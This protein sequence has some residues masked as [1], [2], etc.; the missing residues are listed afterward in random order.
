MNNLKRYTLYILNAID[1]LSIILS[2]FA[3]YY[4]RIFFP[5]TESF[6]GN[7]AN[8]NYFLTVVLVA[9]F[10]VN[11]LL[12]YKDDK[13]L[14]RHPVKEFSA[15]VK[16]SSFVMILVLIYF[17]FAKLN[18]EFSRIFEI[19][20]FV[21]LVL[22]DTILRLMV[23]H[24]VL[25][26]RNGILNHQ[27]I[28]LIASSEDAEKYV[29]I[30]NRSKDW[31][32]RIT[33]VYSS[34]VSFKKKLKDVSVLTKEEEV[35]S[36]DNLD[37]ID[38]VIIFPEDGKEEVLKEW[39]NRFK[40]YGKT[41][42]VQIPQYSL[43][44]SF[45]SLDNIGD[46][47]VVTYRD[48]QPMSIRQQLFKRTID[49][50]I[51]VLFFPF[52]PL[53][54]LIVK[55]FT[56]IESP[57]PVLIRRV[58]VG[59]NNKRFYQYRFRVYRTDAAKRIK[60]KKSPY[61]LIGRFLEK[62]HLDG[63]PLLLNVLTGDM[64]FVGPKAPNLPRYLRMSATQRNL[65]SIR[66]GIVGYWTGEADDTKALQDETEYFE[67]WN[68]F[69][70]ISIVIFC[71]LRFFSFRSLRVHGETHVD[72]ELAFAAYIRERK[73]PIRY[74][75]ALYK[76]ESKPLYSFLKR[77]FDILFSIILIIVLSPLLLFVFIVIL[78]DDGGNPIYT[79]ERVGKDGVRFP[80]YKFRSMRMDAGNLKELL[81][82]EQYDQYL[83]EFK[84][85]NDP[86]ITPTG[87][88][89]RRSSLDELPQ[90]F[91]ILAGSMSFVGPRPILEE[92]VYQNYKK[93]EIAQFLSVRPGLTGFWQAYARNNAVYDDHKRQDMELFYVE[94]RSLWFDIRILFKTI[95]SVISQRGAN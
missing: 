83:K 50:L 73:R 15:S 85:E 35:F 59:K 94:N 47:A 63:L 75:H 8:Y 5:I 64:S 6:Y 71:V 17:N 10:I 19:I 77:A 30:I 31:R 61:T 70:D 27:N 13:Y 22:I 93:K 14:E 26:R 9:Y 60:Q 23:K 44:N 29:G 68:I 4:L 43:S 25:S 49:I 28:L 36:Q 80:I 2:F 79:H 12:I 86:R 88:F 38:G 84:V 46:L 3:A 57:G 18:G 11:F 33:E 42:H 78:A 81:S 89:L 76:P 69:R 67:N 54:Y 51:A 82:P 95:G 20:Y 65:L 91:N 62:I 90:L 48:L 21:I 55:I 24:F 72:E 92:E 7:R 87:E 74:D 32:Y 52:Y 56:E 45:R 41:V 58:R 40:S 16:M 53:V 1:I 39:M 37:S 34:D 66:P